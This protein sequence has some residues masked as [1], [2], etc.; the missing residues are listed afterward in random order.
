MTAQYGALYVA[1]TLFFAFMT[2]AAAF[3]A[4]LGGRFLPRR[5]VAA[6]TWFSLPS[7]IICTVLCGYFLVK[8]LAALARIA[9][10]SR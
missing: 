9:D 10:G 4:I 5:T 2:G 7:G 1:L 8:V 6:V 3:A